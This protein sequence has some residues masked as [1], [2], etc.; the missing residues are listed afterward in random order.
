MQLKVLLPV[1]INEDQTGF[2][3]GCNSFNNI[4]KYL[5][6]IQKFHEESIKG[7]VVSLDGQKAVD[8]VNMPFRFY[9]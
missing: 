2:I 6:T 7:I 5:N 3:K 9:V 4:Q 8:H 1:L